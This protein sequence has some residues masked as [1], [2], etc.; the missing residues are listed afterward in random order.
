MVPNRDILA[1]RERI[2]H[3]CVEHRAILN[4][5][6]GTDLDPFVVA[7]ERGTE[8][9]T[10]IG[11]EPDAADHVGIRCD[12]DLLRVRKIRSNSI[13]AVD[14]HH[15][16]PSE[17]YLGSPAART[18]PGYWLELSRHLLDGLCPGARC[19]GFDIAQGDCIFVSGVAA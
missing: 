19:Y 17:A 3:V 11:P 15:T 18:L 6:A 4:V 9:H 10:D 5:G 14:R 12:P 2:S 1:N 7:T 16:V 8:P 13:K